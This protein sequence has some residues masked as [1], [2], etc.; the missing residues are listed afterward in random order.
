MEKAA[1]SVHAGATR[2]AIA[3]V[4]HNDCFLIGQRPPGVQLAGFW[5]FPGGKVQTSEEPAECA[6]RECREE[7]GIEVEVVRHLAECDHAYDHGLLHLEFF[8][9]RPLPRAPQPLAPFRWVERRSLNRF[10]FPPAND[11]ILRI[12]QHLC[13]ANE[14]PAT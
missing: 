9:C 13:A 3:V 14:E 5:E 4:E 10:R 6:A 8:L 1:Q 7:T 11:E 2:V 12:L